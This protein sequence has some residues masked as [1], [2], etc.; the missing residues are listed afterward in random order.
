MWLDQSFL[1]TFISRPS[2]KKHEK[3][4]KVKSSEQPLKEER[5]EMAG[6]DA[7]SSSTPE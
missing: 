4:E 1:F 5:V 6:V 3:K 7:Q 2:S